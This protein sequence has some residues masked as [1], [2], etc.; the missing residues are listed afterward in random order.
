MLIVLLLLG[1]L[2]WW[3]LRG[4]REEAPIQPSAL[5][6][7]EPER[8]PPAVRTEAGAS[9]PAA[10]EAAPAVEA[11]PPTPAAEEVAMAVEAAPQPPD[12]LTRI[13]GIGPKISRLL[14]EAGIM[15]FAQ[16]AETDVERLREILAEAGLTALA[17]PGTWPEQAR[18]AA[19]GKWDELEALQGELKGGR[20]V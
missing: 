9:A 7:E 4:R 20:R 2:V 15:T 3:W 8:E 17:D 12:D 11:T 5:R 6:P 19:E 16:L 1:L 18:L 14:Q 13:E 10:G